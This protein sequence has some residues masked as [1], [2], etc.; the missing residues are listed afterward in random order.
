MKTEKDCPIMAT[1]QNNKYKK[2]ITNS[3]ALDTT[4]K[5]KIRIHLTFKILKQGQF[6]C[7]VRHNVEVGYTNA[8]GFWEFVKD[9][10]FLTCC[11]C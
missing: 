7:Q 10:N 11:G 1:K 5:K 6:W 2:E 3:L 8:N 9:G 4:K